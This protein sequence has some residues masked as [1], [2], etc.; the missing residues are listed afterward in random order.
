MMIIDLALGNSELYRGCVI[1]NV[2]GR[3][4]LNMPI[5]EAIT[6]VGGN[7]ERIM[8][9]TSA[10]ERESVVITGAMAVW[11]YLIVFHAVVHRFR[12]VFYDDG[13]NGP[14]LISRHG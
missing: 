9:A 4:N 12:E 8:S 7:V 5:S 2:N 6:L 10:A 14:V 1:E 3:L 13:R 11:A